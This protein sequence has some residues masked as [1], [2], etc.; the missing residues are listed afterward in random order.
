[1][2]KIILKDYLE[3]PIHVYIYQPTGKIKG[4]VHIIH[5][6]SEHFARYGLFAEFLNQHGYLAIGCDFLSHGLSTETLDYVHFADKDGDILAYESVVLVKEYIET[7]YKDLDVYLLGHSMGSFLARK[8]ILD[9]PD[10]YKKAVI[11]G[12][13]YVGQGIITMGS[14]L[15]KFIRLFKGPKYVSK[16][17]QNM[18]IDANPN[19]MRKDG[20]IT[21]INEEWLTRD[22]EIQQYYFNSN[23]CGQPFTIQANLDMFQWMSFVN[24]KKNINSGN[25]SMPIYFMSGNNDPLSN[26]GKDIQKLYDVMQALGYEHVQMKLYPECRHEILNELIK[27]EVYADILAFFDAK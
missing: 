8:L 2:E 27:E 16:L 5:G 23:M 12:T 24:N 4:V 14:L 7:N 6:A 9:F 1:M 15:I 3:N 20:I 21:G 26:Y 25:K 22:V 17:I 18:A 11:S 10:F 19:K 13:A